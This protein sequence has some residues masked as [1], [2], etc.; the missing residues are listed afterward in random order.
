MVNG[1][2]EVIVDFWGRPV[3]LTA[4]RWRHITD[5]EG[6]HPYMVY[7]RAELELTLQDPEV[8]IR[9][10]QYPDTARVYHRWFAD[11]V[12]GDK[13]LRVVVNF[14]D[15]GGAFA[16]SAYASRQVIPGEVLWR[17]GVR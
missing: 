10:T 8:V 7:L 4:E 3:R 14:T 15:S 2:D 9:S 5:P 13:W 1:G 6:D 17:K 16:L 12:V 11:T